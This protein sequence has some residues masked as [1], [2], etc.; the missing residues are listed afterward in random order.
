MGG[1]EEA[2]AALVRA[3]NINPNDSKL[4]ALLGQVYR[5]LNKRENALSELEILK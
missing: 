2:E 5:K 3:E 1:L 4:H